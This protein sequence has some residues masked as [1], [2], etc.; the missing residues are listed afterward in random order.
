MHMT[1]RVWEDKGA[2]FGK[3]TLPLRGGTGSLSVVLSV[4]DAQVIA[5]MHQAGIRFNPAAQAEIG[6][7]FGN[8]GK[9]I[10]KVAKNSVIKG[11][12]GVAKGIANSPLVKIIAPEAA[13]A[14]S[15]ASGAAKM[16][17][18]AKAGNPKA[19]LAMKAALAQA[20]LEQQHGKQ[21]PVP[22]SVAKKGPETAMAFRYLVTVTKV[23]A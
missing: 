19:K 13:L 14:I 21:L 3:L 4:S 10:K 20:N 6:S 7:L 9:L 5:Y 15:A 17:T 18:A 2:V 11:V 12:L 22:T 23:A 8:I 1:I 16:I